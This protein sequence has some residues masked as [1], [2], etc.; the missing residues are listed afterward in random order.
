MRKLYLLSALLLCNFLLAQSGVGIGTT[1]PQQKLH[2]HKSVGTVRVE[3]L[4]KDNSE[5]NGGNSDLTA[6]Y[7]LY[8]DSNG[9]LSL[10]LETLSNSNGLDAIDNATIP[11]STIKLTSADADGKVEAIFFTYDITV[12]RPSILEI[13]YSVSFEVYQ[14]DTPLTMIRDTGARRV[15]TYY[16]LDNLT[17][18]YGQASKCYMNNNI[19]NPAP[20]NASEKMGA[21]GT[22]YNSSSTYIQ[23]PTGAHTI[24]FKAEVSSNLPSM[25]TLVRMAVSTDSVF[26]RLY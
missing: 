9:V 11:T 4:D 7:P 19:N 21:V 14:T 24:K 18:K 1:D 17:R 26:M 22:M 2:L 12:A 10:S 8:V 23:L 5:Y 13:K 6:T 16:T 15:S 20:F 3:S 25:N